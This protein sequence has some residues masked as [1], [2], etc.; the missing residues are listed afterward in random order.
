M[1]AFEYEKIQRMYVRYHLGCLNQR[2]RTNQEDSGY[3][4]E[5]FNRLL[6]DVYITRLYFLY[7][8]KNC[9]GFWI[10][11][12]CNGLI[13]PLRSEDLILTVV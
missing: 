5:F 13:I 1:K 11:S 9:N 4:K 6:T 7:L 3:A 8:S 10:D 12:G 2:V